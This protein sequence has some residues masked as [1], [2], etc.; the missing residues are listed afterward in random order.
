MRLKVEIPKL[1][2]MIKNVEKQPNINLHVVNR[3][4][5]GAIIVMDDEVLAPA[6]TDPPTVVCRVATTTTEEYIISQ[7]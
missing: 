3:A 6:D 4:R 2:Q 7:N 1:H 5:N